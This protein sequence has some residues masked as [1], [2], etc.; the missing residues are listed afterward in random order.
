MFSSLLSYVGFGGSSTSVNIRTVPVADLPALTSKRDKRLNQL[1]KLN[2]VQHSILYNH[3]RFHNHTPHHLGSAYLL[4]GSAEHLNHLYDDINAHDRLEPWE[5]SP[6]E[7][8]Q[9]DHRDFLGKRNYQR[10]WIDFFEDQLL[11][12]N[13]SWKNVVMKYIFEY[14][15]KDSPNHHSMFNCL[16]GGLGHPLIHLGY[17]FE[18]NSREVAMEAL[19]LAATCY[20]P[21]LASLVNQSHPEPKPAT[22]DLF[23]VFSRVHDDPKLNNLF[24][25]PGNS[26]LNHILETPDLLSEVLAHYASWSITNP[27]AQFSQSQHLAAALLVSTSPKL[28]GHGYD[29]FLVH[30]LTSS[31]AVRILL[32]FIPHQY[33]V[34]LVKEWFLITLLIYIAQLCP[35]VPAPSTTTVSDSDHPIVSYDLKERNWSFVIDKAL[36]GK[37]ATD[38]HFVKG[39]RAM[40]VGADTWGDK[41]KWFLRCA[42]RF[43]DE[44]HGWGGFGEEDEEAEE[45]RRE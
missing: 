40:M 24:S 8:A 16:V 6:G 14:G 32:P 22:D 30:L 42:V 33:H 31:H 21:K 36:K 12:N 27:T 2:H 7:I 38:A 10:A 34:T 23:A 37:H 19:G 44:F 26:N 25:R 3:L 39:C 20:D 13:Y 4:N 15:P 18:L 45:C 41:D 1:L 17:A 43:A 35:A 29:F 5:D 28:G 11:E 9:H